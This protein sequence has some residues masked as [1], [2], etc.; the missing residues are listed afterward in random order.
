MRQMEKVASRVP[1][2]TCPGNHERKP[3]NFSHYDARFSMLG[4]RFDHDHTFPPAK[5]EPQRAARI[6]PR[7]PPP[8][9]PKPPNPPLATRINNHYHSVDIGPFHIVL[10]NTE[11]YYY[12]EYGWTQIRAQYEWLR[13]DLE[14]A[15][16]NR[17][18]RPW[19]IVLGHRPLYC[20][21][22][23]GDLSCNRI[24]LERARLRTGVRMY[25][26]DSRGL[27]FGLEELFFNASVDLQIY[28]HEH[29]VAR[30][31][32]VYDHDV[33]LPKE[34]EEKVTTTTTTTLA[35]DDI[36]TTEPSFTTSTT[37]NS[38]TITTDPTTTT[39]PSITFDPF[40]DF[41]T[42]ITSTDSTTTTTDF[43]STTTTD[44]ITTTEPTT[45]EP[46]TTTL[47]PTT[48]TTLSPTTT[49]TTTPGPTTTSAPVNHYNDPG[50]PIHITSGS[51]G[52][53][54]LHPLINPLAKQSEMVAKCYYD[55]GYTRLR[56]LDRL[57]IVVEQ[58]SVDQNGTV[59]DSQQISKSVD[60]PE[61]DFEA[62]EVNNWWRKR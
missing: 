10:F 20:L 56:V 27:E 14:K 26:D 18:K 22:L 46:T 57:T 4:D 19:I 30:F 9:K 41:T 49:P 48:T 5:V 1:Y 58:V 60:R 36:T 47:A 61:W 25:G 31:L 16:R 35:P 40:T 13:A 2:M 52:N 8:P 12:T 53:R 15:N 55:Y 43:T 6:S 32:P 29:F 42:T 50:G 11:F 3:W 34:K 39:D 38:I 28:G 62:N 7:S 54:E 44:F 33:M 45:T 21:K 24:T 23:T 17:Q 51:A 37:D 59:V